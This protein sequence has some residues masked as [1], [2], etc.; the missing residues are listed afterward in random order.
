[1]SEEL[2]RKPGIS[3][4]AIML[5]MRR[6]GDV[7]FF[8]EFLRIF[9]GFFGILCFLSV[10]IIGKGKKIRKRKQNGKEKERI[11]GIDRG[12]RREMVSDDRRKGKIGEGK[13]VERRGKGEN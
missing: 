6:Y 5:K 1:V 2:G 3:E 4:N 12:R 13:H 8:I 11:D 7:L 9:E 10:S